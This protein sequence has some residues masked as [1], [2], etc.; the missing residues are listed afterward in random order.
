MT[1]T[2]KRKLKSESGASLLLALLFLL[3]CIMVSS[4]ILMASVSNAGK[5]RSN[6]EEHQ[7]YMAL[8][9]AVNTLCDEINRTE[10]RGQYEYTETE[11]E[12]TNFDTGT[13]TK[14]ILK[15]FKQLDGA[16]NH[17]GANEQ[18]GFLESVIL[19]D[20][21]IIFADEIQRSLNS[22]EFKTFE[23]KKGA[24]AN[25]HALTITSQTGTELDN[26]VVKVQL[27]VVEESYAIEL[28][29]TLDDYHIEAEL[30]PIT[31]I[32]TL[33][34]TLQKGVQSKTEPLK[35]KV[36]WITVGEGEVE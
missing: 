32:P 13:K 35:W 28:T 12:I 27:S 15:H 9:S 19:S 36:G 2:L 18:K 17:I 24:V 3:I 29:A 25:S 5:Y 7:T 26:N 20:L 4:S 31:S 21:D 10:Y 1:S 11:Q 23:V 6:M 30:T 22:S 33:P 16:Y 14:K 8:S 34:D